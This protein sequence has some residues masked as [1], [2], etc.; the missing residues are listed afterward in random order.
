MSAITV[1]KAII[2]TPKINGKMKQTE[3]SLKI[4]PMTLSDIDKHFHLFCDLCDVN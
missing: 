4:Q 3:M 1:G 2:K